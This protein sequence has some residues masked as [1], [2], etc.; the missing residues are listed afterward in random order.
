M[1]ISTHRLIQ[2]HTQFFFFNDM[3]KYIH[4]CV[5]TNLHLTL[6]HA[7]DYSTQSSSDHGIFIGNTGVGHHFLLQRMFL[8]QE[9]NPQLFFKFIPLLMDGYFHI[10]TLVNNATVNIGVHASFQSM[11]FSG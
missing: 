6:C 10:L 5:V 9:S 3:F 4:F 2:I 8:T 1:F 7:V 11:T